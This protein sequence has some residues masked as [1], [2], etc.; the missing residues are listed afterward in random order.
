VSSD[1]V[2][3]VNESIILR[4][5]DDD[6]ILFKENPEIVLSGVSGPQGPKGDAGN[7]GTAATI[8]VGTTTTGAPGSSATVSNAGTSS[9]AVF[10]F[11]IPRGDTG[12]TGDPGAAATIAAGTTTTGAAGSSAAVSNVGTSSAAVFN[13]TIP[14]G[15]T[16]SAGAAG[17]S[18]AL[19]IPIGQWGRYPAPMTVRTDIFY[20]YL[21]A[22]PFVVTTT[23]T[24]DRIAVRTGGV[25]ISGSARLGIYNSNGCEPTTRVIDAGSISFTD[26]NT[27]YAITINVTLSPGVY[28]LAMNIA[29]GF[30]SW[31][32]YAPTSDQG[33]FQLMQSE[34][35]TGI[36]TSV[37]ADVAGIPSTLSGIG[38]SAINAAAVFVRRSA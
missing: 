7:N 22:H 38:Y 2:L 19:T 28:W 35:L 24:Y 5:S 37:F 20:G 33:M 11:T 8:A 3:R 21:M 12:T 10:N 15:D 9:A 16:G 23:S 17:I 18:N 4:P 25:S 1:I 26:S 31:Q 32:G 36:F 13:F 34:T 6:I 29:S 30:A 14:R 27:T